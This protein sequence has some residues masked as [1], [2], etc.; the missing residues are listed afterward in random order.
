MAAVWASISAEGAAPE[1]VVHHRVREEDEHVRHYMVALDVTFSST[2]Q[3]HQGPYLS[4]ARVM[5]AYVW[6]STAHG[7]APGSRNPL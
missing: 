7:S 1:E 5:V 3:Y 4:C 6:V 2:W